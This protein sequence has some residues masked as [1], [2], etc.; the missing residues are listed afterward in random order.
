M[1]QTTSSK[2]DQMT[3]RTAGAVKDLAG[4]AQDAASRM[5]AQGREASEGVQEVAGNI[6]G[7]IDKSVTDQP[8]ATLAM[9]AGIGFVLGALWKS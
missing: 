5:T 1:A 6:K 4:Q 8:M 9:A 7:A 2:V 3:D